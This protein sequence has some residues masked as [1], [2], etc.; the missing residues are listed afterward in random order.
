MG[1]VDIYLRRSTKK[2]IFGR[3]RNPALSSLTVHLPNQ[4][5]VEDVYD[6]ANMSKLGPKDVKQRYETPSDLSIP[7]F[8]RRAVTEAKLII[9]EMDKAQAEMDAPKLA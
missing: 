1:G 7:D 5:S 6:G 4:R 8:L 2:V 9:A 3:P